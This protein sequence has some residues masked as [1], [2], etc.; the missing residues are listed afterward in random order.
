[1]A[2]FP[3]EVKDDELDTLLTNA[4]MWIRSFPNKDARERAVRDLIRRTGGRVMP[5]V[6]Y[7]PEEMRTADDPDLIGQ[8]RDAAGY[9]ILPSEA[10]DVAYAESTRGSRRTRDLS[11]PSTKAKVPAAVTDTDTDISPPKRKRPRDEG[12]SQQSVSD[13]ADTSQVC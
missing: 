10:E 3:S 9:P 4:N 6:P 5:G 1:M 12:T 7:L 2:V 11:L 8:T 13:T